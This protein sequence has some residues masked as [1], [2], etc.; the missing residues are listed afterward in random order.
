MMS[1]LFGLLREIELRIFRERCFEAS[2]R[3]FSAF[4]IFV[5]ACVLLVK[6]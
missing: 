6:L 5:K 3:Q 4:K 2:S 1:A